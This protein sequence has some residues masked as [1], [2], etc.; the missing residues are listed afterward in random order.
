M[1][2]SRVLSK[3]ESVAT[4]ATV[5][6]L[7]V[8]L[9]F[10]GA[11]SRIARA[12]N[13]AQLPLFLPPP[14]SP[15]I[16]FV[17]D[18]SG[19]MM[20][21]VMPDDYAYSNLTNGSVY[22]VFPRVG[23][24]YGSSDYTNNVATVADNV[25][26][27]ALA[28][29]SAW[30]TV[31]YDPATTY[32]PW[33]KPDKTSYPNASPACAL[34]NPE[35]IGTGAN[36]CRN[37]TANIANSSVTTNWRTCSGTTCSGTTTTLPNAAFW[38]ATYFYYD[39]SKG[40][41]GKWTWSN[42][43]KVEIKSTTPSYSG[44]G[45]A[46]RTDCTGGICTYA[47]EIQNFANWYTYYRSRILASR[48]GI[49]KAFGRQPLWLSEEESK[50]R[51]GFGSINTV[52]KSIDGVSGDTV[53][54]G[55]RSFWGTGRAAFFNSLYQ[56][57]IPAQGTPLV[58]ALQGAGQYYQRT[59][60]QGPWSKTPGTASS[61]TFASCRQS[62][63]ILM[64]DGYWN[65]TLASGGA[66]SNNDGTAGPT[67][68]GPNGASYTYSP[69]S[70]FTDSRGNTLAD[71]AMYYWKTDLMSSLTNRV[72]TSSLDPAF[73]QHMVTFG[74]GLGVTGSIDPATAFA[75][76]SANP[77]PAIT[78]PDPSGATSTPAK[79]D[80]L[81][82]AGVNGRGGFFSASNPTVFANKLAAVLDSINALQKS[83]A[84]ALAATSSQRSTDTQLFQARFENNGPD[85]SGELRAYAI[86]P[87]T[88]A[89]DPMP[90]WTTSDSGKIPAHATRK[91]FT[92]FGNGSS[93]KVAF[94]WS[95]LSAAQQSALQAAGVTQDILNW[96]RGDQSQ[97]KPNGSLRKRSRLLG[98]I[99][100]SDPAYVGEPPDFGYSATPGYTAF[101]QALKTRAK[102]LYVGAND[103]MLHAFDAVT[104]A[105]KFAF[106]PKAAHANLASLTNPDYDHKYFVDG[107]PY[108][109]DAYLS[110]TWKSILIGTMRAG[111]RS[112]FALDVTNPVQANGS[113]DFNTTNILWEFTDPDLGYTIGQP[114]IGRL[115]NGTWVVVFGNGYGS[116]P[117]YDAFLFVVNLETGALIAKIGTGATGAG[118]A[119]NPNGV[120]T[121]ALLADSNRNL[122][123]AYAG[124]LKGNLWKFNLTGTLSNATQPAFS[125]VPLFKARDSANRPQPITAP[126]EISKHPKGGYL[127][128]FG[129]GKYFETGDNE[130]E[131]TPVQHSLY[132]I[133]DTA[134][135]VSNAWTGGSAITV[136]NRSVLLAQTITQVVGASGFNW[137][138]IS[139]NQI[140][141]NTHRGW[142]LDLL[143][144]SS[145]R[146]DN[147][148][149]M[150]ER[151]IDAPILSAGRVF[152]TTRIQFKAADPCDPITGVSWLMGFDL[153]TGGRKD[154]VFDVNGDDTVD[155]N[156]RLAAASGASA[157]GFQSTHG[158]ARLPTLISGG[159]IIKAYLP[160][161]AMDPANPEKL[162]A[163]I[164]GISDPDVGR[165]SWRQLR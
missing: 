97:E 59:D 162:P 45:R 159:K 119:T 140:D 129:T 67:I 28:R 10:G 62:F 165:Q 5:F 37:L 57:P 48:A 109:A 13:I 152:F 77:P 51:V 117:G 76:I 158:M 21:E 54:Q 9:V 153:L 136:T 156:D 7:M 101:R 39:S 32:S 87:T 2:S 3:M 18:D 123:A 20:F 47:Q 40:A 130:P 79:I 64:T 157:S 35:R 146:P 98:D 110:G 90:Q 44:H 25:A 92:T 41:A 111:G 83:S 42:Y 75:A 95:A 86:N 148:Q 147:S 161:S 26:F 71:V 138:V 66:A 104:G 80:D 27:T 94:E 19:S 131:A 65:G 120:A 135:L 100:N 49:G 29:S 103:G 31:Y 58:K 116:D 91:I 142:Y 55:L 88:G 145:L 69:V 139:Q 43:T 50:L 163:D 12:G 155:A 61:A 115:Q 70:P 93:D 73:W 124:D 68:T 74:V 78:W 6:L 8:L 150:S 60:N 81:L 141:W 84:S 23:G 134:T 1:N 85:W 34:H 114:S 132:G 22:Y 149:D 82:H 89:V 137:R 4:L 16:M 53:I 72:P 126:L 160:G 112:L 154:D 96:V 108:V 56:H 151:V 164:V 122:V 33:D 102:M 99:I 118:D 52:S 128:L 30:N 17:L 121:P 24:V 105:E 36:Y 15:N 113:V 125:G 133:R 63:T 127:I 46:S 38:T 107:A 11:G 14:V 144:Q 143:P 106:I